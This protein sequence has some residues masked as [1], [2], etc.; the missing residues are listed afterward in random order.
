MPGNF[1]YPVGGEKADRI[2]KMNMRRGREIWT[3][4]NAWLR[5]DLRPYLLDRHH[6]ALI[7]RFERN[8][9]RLFLTVED[10]DLNTLAGARYGSDR[11]APPCTFE[12]IFEGVTYAEHRRADQQD[13]LRWAPPPVQPAQ[14]LLAR[15]VDQDDPGF[16][17]I[18]SYDRLEPLCQVRYLMVE[19]AEIRVVPFPRDR[20]IEYYGANAGRLFDRYEAVRHEMMLSYFPHRVAELGVDWPPRNS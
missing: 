3:E 19:A 6:D 13:R 18:L 7:S 8:G 16:R 20:W 12:L 5:P 15:F 14:W 1:D 11:P 2:F 10:M 4:Q 17:W 9:D